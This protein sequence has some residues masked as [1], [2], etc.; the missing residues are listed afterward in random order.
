[1]FL[2]LGPSFLLSA[3]C[4]SNSLI[5]YSGSSL[6]FCS[7]VSRAISSKESWNV[8]TILFAVLHHFVIDR[9]NIGKSFEAKKNYLFIL[10]SF[11]QYLTEPTLERASCLFNLRQSTMTAASAGR[12]ALCGQF[13]F[14]ESGSLASVGV[15]LPSVQRFY[16]KDLF[17]RR[18]SRLT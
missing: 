1:M 7:S 8:Q 6:I 5:K 12:T 18:S 2:Y 13:G 3:S 15:G 16:K 9:I 4:L 10:L 14:S 17:W 11:A